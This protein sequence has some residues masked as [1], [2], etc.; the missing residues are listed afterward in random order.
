VRERLPESST[1][2]IPFFGT[3]A[4]FSSLAERTFECSTWAVATEHTSRNRKSIVSRARR[5]TIDTRI[6]EIGFRI[7]LARAECIMVTANG[8]AKPALINLKS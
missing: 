4:M 1:T 5:S 3:I 6:L 7:R 8:V 2:V